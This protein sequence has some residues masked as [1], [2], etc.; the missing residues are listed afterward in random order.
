LPLSMAFIGLTLLSAFLQRF[1]HLSR[2][3]PR[4]GEAVGALDSGA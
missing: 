2:N 1:M 3:G 4:S